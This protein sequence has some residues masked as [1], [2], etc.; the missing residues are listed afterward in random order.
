MGVLPRSTISCGRY[1][2][3]N[4]C[5]LSYFVS[6]E[7]LIILFLQAWDLQPEKRPNFHDVKIKLGQLKIEYTQ[8]VNWV[9]QS[10]AHRQ[11][12]HWGLVRS[13][14]CNHEIRY[15]VASN[16]R[17]RKGKRDRDKYT[18]LRVLLFFSLYID[19]R[20]CTL[21]TLVFFSLLYFSSIYCDVRA[22]SQG[23]ISG[24]FFFFLGTMIL[25]SL[26]IMHIDFK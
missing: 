10:R 22:R 12:W 13:N 20:R 1:V 18:D 14:V 19:W 15:I 2:S 11:R 23:T 16:A 3:S 9:E 6:F 21:L 7:K 8:A 25:S 5:S 17:T 24:C 4:L 26:R